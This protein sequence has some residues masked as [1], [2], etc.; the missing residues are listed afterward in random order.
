M[1][2]SQD[3]RIK[4]KKYDGKL[5]IGT[6]FYSGFEFKEAVLEYALSKARNIVQEG[7]DNNKLIFKCGLEGLL[8]L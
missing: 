8:L 4:G 6:S 7:S 1:C 3:R 2:L 5:A